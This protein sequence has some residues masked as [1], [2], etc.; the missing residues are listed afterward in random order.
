MTV[1][2]RICI[3]GVKRNML[4]SMQCYLLS[5]DTLLILSKN[6]AH[7]EKPMHKISKI[8]CF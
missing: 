8:V 5:F 7:V 6:A 4:D 3:K 1:L 2:G